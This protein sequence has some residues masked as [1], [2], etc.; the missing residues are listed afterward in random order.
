MRITG[1]SAVL[2]ADIHVC[3]AIGDFYILRG[4]AHR[5][6]IGEDFIP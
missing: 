1:D 2:D 3:T 6:R 5:L 4:L